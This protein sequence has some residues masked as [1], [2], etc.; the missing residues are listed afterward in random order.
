MR[1]VV[2]AVTTPTRRRVVVVGA[3]A[4]G[5]RCASR[6]A[7]LDPTADVL[8]LEARR[9]FSYAACGLPYVLSGDIDGADALRRTLD[10]SLRDEAYFRNVKG[11][12]VRTGWRVIGVDPAARTLNVIDG[13]GAPAVIPWDELVLATGA[14]PKRLAVQ[15][16]HPRV[17][18]FH[19]LEDLAP[20]HQG[21]AR[22]RIGHAAIVGAGLV[23]CEVAEAFRSLWGA[24]ATLIEAA[25]WPLPGVL[26][27]EIAGMVAEG[28]RRKGVRLLTG[29]PVDTI[30][31]GESR[32]AI[33]VGGE[34]IE[35]DVAIVAVGVEP[36]VSLARMAGVAI[37]ESGAI[38][39][40]EQMAT[41]VPHVWAAGDCVE[42]VHAVSGRGVHLPLGSLANRQ[43]RVLGSVLTGLDERFGPVAGAVA[44]KAF[45]VNVAAVGITR[46]VAERLGLEARSVWIMTHDS[47]HY[48]P[49]AREI[50]LQLTYEPGSG[51]VLGVQGAGEGEVA[52]RIDVATQ[53]IARHATIAE[54]ACL[55]HAYAPPYAPAIDPLAVAAFVADNQERGIEALS[56]LEPLPLAQTLDVRHD[57][58][59]AERPVGGGEVRA[60]AL[61][62]LRAASLSECPEWT[63]VCE[64][65]TRSAEGVCWMLAHG[66]K[67]RYVGGG[68][69][70]R[71]LAGGG[72]PR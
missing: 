30:D 67:A 64:R 29:N 19:T 26:D 46:N 35:A 51:R 47:A 4:A 49:E 58:E 20:L 10:G 44:V 66:R 15:P 59:R 45:D 33:A 1:A 42:V 62:T 27:R 12:E 11:V 63:V 38:A 22:G 6:L 13:G 39:V 24:D 8:V 53:L 60:V 37:G 52:K 14:R 70:L 2:G 40:D 5:L 32:V 57:D 3:S 61:E 56:P 43:G 18:S 65:G 16:D 34:R 55:E 25:P 7:R 31:A 68:L 72:E 50:A 9:E 48:W 23:G 17:C 54:V 71:E 36:E 41:S 28:I 21:L 69:R